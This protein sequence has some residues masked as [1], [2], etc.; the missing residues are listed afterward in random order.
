MV[1][2]AP[3]WGWPR[4]FGP[5]LVSAASSNDPT[6]VATLAIVGATTGYGLCWLVVLVIPVLALVQSI[7]AS[8]G[9][10]SGTSLQG[11]IRR[12]FGLKWS[13]A[14]LTAIVGVSVLTLAADVKAGSE[15]LALLTRV[16]ADAFVV[17]FAAVTATLLI[18]HS[19]ARIER[20]LSL[21]PVIFI[22]YAAS[23]FFARAD[24]V[25]LLRS[26]A[27]PHLEFSAPYV[28]GAIAV[29]GTTLTSYVYIWES[30]EVAERHPRGAAVAGFQ[31]DAVA[32]MLAVGV[33]F[34]MIVV[35]CAATLG[36][37]NLPIQTANDAA[38]ALVPLA[39]PWA[40]TLFGIGLLGSAALAVPVLAATCA[41]VAAHTFGW[42]A[43]LDAPVGQAKRFYAVLLG[44]LAVSSA[45]ALLPV[46]PI[47]LLFWASIAGGIATPLTLYFLIAVARDRGTMGERRIGNVPAALTWAATSIVVVA[48]L[49]AF[50]FLCVP[51]GR[52]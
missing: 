7:A 32:G 49:A 31:R 25:A 48:A 17:P 6:T 16:P 26:V 13:L 22:C 28:L 47:S 19:Y 36:A 8:V 23:A 42:S 10:V 2:R 51:F 3:K 27:A 14:T 30:V 50:V 29:L 33:I 40:G 38:A 4:F 5:G 45:A 46:P 15:A 1:T 20:Y 41:Y 9:A 39:G 11:A 37:H 34:L 43:G 21:L 12:R 18:T 44:A 52:A 35:A 24:L